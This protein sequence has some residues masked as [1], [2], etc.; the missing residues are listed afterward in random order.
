VAIAVGWRG[1][2]RAHK[3]LVAV[4]LLQVAVYQLSYLLAPADPEAL[5]ATT[6]MRLL[7]HLAPVAAYLSWSFLPP[8]PRW[9]EP[10]RGERRD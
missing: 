4:L 2:S 7:L 8:L 6:K 10:P 1:A 3:V 9:L 5:V